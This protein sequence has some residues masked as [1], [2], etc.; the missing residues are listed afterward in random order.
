MD[1][2]QIEYFVALYDERSI[3]KAARRLSVV[4]PALSMQISRLE[5]TFKTKLFERTSRGVVPTD[6]ARTFY[7]LCQNILGDVDEARR[8]LR[9]AS[10][11]VT[12]DL[13]VGLMPSVANS[14]LP[15]VLA[16][17]KSNYPDVTLRIVEAYSGSLLDQLYSG[18]LDLA[19]INNTGTTTITGDVG[20]FPTT[21][22]TGFASVTIAGTNHAGDAVTQG[23]KNDLVTAYTD[24]AN[25]TPCT[26]LTTLTGQNLT[27]GTYC[28]S[29]SAGLT[30]P[31]TLSGFGVYIFQIGSALTTASGSSVLLTNNAQACGVWWQVTSSA[32]FGTGSSF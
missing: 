23:A 31:L 13:T 1:L 8:C 30:G 17:Y 28:F 16:E 14:V 10:G 24:A 26:T 21:S 29:S 19:V 22:E 2:R 18:K 7:G 20:T 6:T 12:G 3:T 4:Q 32:T 15:A 11:K 5:R 25:Q 9:D 27:P